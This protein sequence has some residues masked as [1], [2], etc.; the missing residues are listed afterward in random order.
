M[1]LLQE[2]DIKI[3]NGNSDPLEDFNESQEEPNTEQYDLI[4]A[5]VKTIF[6]FQTIQFISYSV[7]KSW[8]SLPPKR[9]EMI[10]SY[11][12]SPFLQE[13]IAAFPVTVYRASKMIGSNRGAFEKFVVC[14]KCDSLYNYE[15]AYRVHNDNLFLI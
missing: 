13:F 1:F 15:E 8:F 11:L 9:L 2:D 7:V 10:N 5:I 12:K 14:K 3:W 6:W 4:S